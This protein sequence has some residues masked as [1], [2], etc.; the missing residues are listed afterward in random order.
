[1][2]A[3]KEIFPLL[4]GNGYVTDGRETAIIG[5]ERN[6][7]FSIGYDLTARRFY[8]SK[9]GMLECVLLP[10]ESVFAESEEIIAFGVNV[11]GRVGLRNSR[12]RMGLSLDAPV[13]HPGHK[14]RVYFRLTNISGDAIRLKSGESYASMFFERLSEPPESPYNGS[15]QDEFDY[16]NLGDYKSAYSEQIQSLDG[17]IK[18]L[19]SI[20]R[21]V[22]GNVATILT[23]FVA[24]F[25]ILNVNISLAQGGNGAGAYAV[26]NLSTV[27][28]VS[29][30]ALLL[31]HLLPVGGKRCLWLW[32]ILAVC[33]LVVLVL[34]VM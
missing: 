15:F 3:D 16:R 8:R 2:L 27:G 12:L 13:Y 25:T 5:G 29:A 34:A 30:L 22:Y 20:E 7:V 11:A 24:V 19:E 26:F 33:L 10:G 6:K 28:A 32:A 14:T 21:T 1:V 23:V 4:R 17:K 31:S 9:D 18:T